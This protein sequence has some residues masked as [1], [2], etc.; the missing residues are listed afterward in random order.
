MCHKNH[1]KIKFWFA[2]A[3]NGYILVLAVTTIWRSKIMDPNLLT[4]LIPLL[5]QVESG[6]DPNAVGDGGQAVGVLQIHPIMVAE[7]NRILKDDFYDLE[8]RLDPN[9][10]AA[11]AH[12]YLYYW[13][14]RRL[15]RRAT[16]EQ[17]IVL[18][19]RLWNG[20]PNGHKKRATF[21]YGE[22]TRKL[23]RQATR[24]TVTS[25]RAG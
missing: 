10:S 9:E 12:I 15:P 18:L 7:V 17:S 5:C 19:A 1:K 4:I 14:E 23:Y 20:G 22:K 24:S 6:G 11:M 16:A 8:D 3:E 21:Q 13:G 25:R 2:L